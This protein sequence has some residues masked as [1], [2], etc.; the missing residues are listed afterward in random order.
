MCENPLIHRV[1]CPANTDSMEGTSCQRETWPASSV[2]SLLLVEHRDRVFARLAAE[3]TAM[4]MRVVRATGAREAIRRYVDRPTD[5]L[6]VHAD[7]PGESAWLLSAKLRLT[8]PAAHIWVY[9]RRLSAF[10]VAA[11]NFLMVD[12]LIEYQGGLS[13]LSEEILAR[14]EAAVRPPASA[15]RVVDRTACNEAVA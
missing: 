4:G 12:E 8:H 14:F 5:L 11:A 1:Y 9:G 2:R 7:L 3:L 6:V 10:D 13:R 15:A